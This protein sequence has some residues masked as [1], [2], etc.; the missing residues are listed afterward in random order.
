MGSGATALKNLSLSRGRGDKYKETELGREAGEI[1]KSNVHGLAEPDDYDFDQEIR[2]CPGG[3]GFQITWHPTHCCGR[4][5]DNDGHGERCEMK[6]V[7]WQEASPCPGGCGYQFTNHSSGYCCGRCSQNNGHG[8]QCQQK[9]MTAEDDDLILTSGL[10]PETNTPPSSGGLSENDDRTMNITQLK[11][12]ADVTMKKAERLDVTFDNSLDQ[13]KPAKK[14]ALKKVSLF[15]M[16]AEDMFDDNTRYGEKRLSPKGFSMAEGELPAKELDD[17]VEFVQY[18]LYYRPDPFQ[19]LTNEWL[20][21]AEAKPDNIYDLE[22]KEF[23]LVEAD[24][25]AVEGEHKSKEQKEKEA[26]RA[27]QKAEREAEVERI[28]E[29][30]NDQ[31]DGWKLWLR[32]RDFRSEFKVQ[33]SIS[34]EEEKLKD[35]R[36]REKAAVR[37]P[38][39]VNGKSWVRA[40]VD[41]REPK[42]RTICWRADFAKE[43]RTDANLL[44]LERPTMAAEQVRELARK[45]WGALDMFYWHVEVVDLDGNRELWS[46]TFIGFIW[47]YWKRSMLADHVAL[48]EDQLEAQAK[49]EGLKDLLPEGLSD[50][51][52]PRKPVE[53]PKPIWKPPYVNVPSDV[54][55]IIDRPALPP[56]PSRFQHHLF[57]KDGP[58]EKKLTK[59]L[60]GSEGLDSMLGTSDRLQAAARAMLR[61]EAIQTAKDKI[62]A[63]ANAEAIAEAAEQREA[64]EAAKKRLE[65]GLAAEE[66]E[67]S[68][69][70]SDEDAE[71]EVQV[72]SKY[73][74]AALGSISALTRAKAKGKPKQ[75]KKEAKQGQKAKASSP[76]HHKSSAPAHDT[77]EPQAKAKTKAK[78]RAKSKMSALTKQRGGMKGGSAGSNMPM[79]MMR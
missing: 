29:L 18:Q 55:H 10:P 33:P 78:A 7:P 56:I 20:D 47:E 9:P 61:S 51:L 68:S 19:F 54:F 27:K 26:E 40:P 14:S 50:G 32:G 57:Y 43:A 3:C 15:D 22:A 5:G 17:F 36:A 2:A 59:A 67:S 45:D 48:Y 1:D 25:P 69:D 42:G 66:S 24:H 28:D 44:G 49:R 37:P 41:A 73:R 21:G 58:L 77:P 4:C 11:E 8:E 72:K 6:P 64:E 53:W 23:D 63:E 38:R 70:S 12:E 71:E 46:P 76:E 75:G 30:L 65:Q 52:F 60:V 79:M 35:F 39:R 34:K 13:T 31:A 62:W 74:K 16:T